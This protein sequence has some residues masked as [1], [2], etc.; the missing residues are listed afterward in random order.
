MFSTRFPGRSGE[1]RDQ[2][3]KKHTSYNE[4]NYSPEWI[5]LSISRGSRKVP[6]ISAILKRLDGILRRYSTGEK[7]VSLLDAL[8]HS[9]R[10]SYICHRGYQQEGPISKGQRFHLHL[11]TGIH[12]VYTLRSLLII[13][14]P[15]GIPDFL[16]GNFFTE[17]PGDIPLN[18]MLLI[19]FTLGWSLTYSAGR[20]ELSEDVTCLRILQRGRLSQFSPRSLNMNRKYSARFRKI[21][22]LSCRAYF[23]FEPLLRLSIIGIC[24]YG[25]IVNPVTAKSLPFLCGEIIWILVVAFLT[26]IAL[27][28]S[29]WYVVHLVMIIYYALFSLLSLNESGRNLLTKG[30]LASGDLEVRMFLRWQFK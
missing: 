27:K 29:A 30:A 8:E 28:A 9:A 14:D 25:M 22:L 13:L 26:N 18:A 4:V 11:F 3:D 16:L 21:V 24:I 23:D 7:L 12:L 15:D 2:W 19:G 6:Q 20:V 1:K 17:L 5:N 10:R